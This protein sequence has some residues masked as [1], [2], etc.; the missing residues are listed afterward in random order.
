MVFDGMS[1]GLLRVGESRPSFI[2]QLNFRLEFL[3]FH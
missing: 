1:Y 3:I 2:G